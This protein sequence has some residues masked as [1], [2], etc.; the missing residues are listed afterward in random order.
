VGDLTVDEDDPPVRTRFVGYEVQGILGQ[1]GS[2]VVYLAH[3]EHHGRLV[4]IK[5]LAA[6]QWASPKQRLRFQ[7]E[8][9]TL[10]ELDIPGVVPIIDGGTTPNGTPWY[11]MEYV[12]GPSVAEL[13]QR[14]GTIPP[15]ELARVLRELARVVQAVH[16][17]G[18]VH[19]DIKPSNVL[20]SADGQPFL[21]DFGLV[22]DERDPRRLT[23]STQMLGTPRYLAPEQLDGEIGDWRLVDIHGLGL[24]L[25][26]ALTG[27]VARGSDSDLGSSS[28][29]GS[30]TP[31]GLLWIARRATERQP[32]ERYPNAGA[33]A[34]DLEA[35]LQGRRVVPLSR[36]VGRH[37]PARLR[38]WRWQ[39]GIGIALGLLGLQVVT[40]WAEQRRQSNREARAQQIV[41]AAQQDWALLLAEGEAEGAASLFE[42]RAANPA[43][44]GTQALERAWLSYGRHAL[45]QRHHDEA[46]HAFGMALAV[47]RTQQTRTEAARGLA[48]TFRD[49]GDHW[50]LA[51]LLDMLP[52]IAPEAGPQLPRQDW[53][54]RAMLRGD[55]EAASATAS[56]DQAVLLYA[57]RH[58]AEISPVSMG[59]WDSDGDGIDEPRCCAEIDDDPACGPEGYPPGTGHE[60]AGEGDYLSFRDA[61]SIILTRVA[62]DGVSSPQLWQGAMWGL[63]EIDGQPYTIMNDPSLGLQT[64]VDGVQ[65]PAHPETRR[66]HSYTLDLAGGDLDG[67]GSRELAVTMSLPFAWGVRLYRR[68]A[69]GELELIAQR[70]WTKAGSVDIARSPG[71]PRLLVGSWPHLSSRLVY[72]PD[73]VSEGRLE[74]LRLED[75]ALWLESSVDLPSPPGT[76]G[77][78]VERVRTCDVDGDGT[79]EIVLS[80]VLDRV[81]RPRIMMLMGWCDDGSVGEPLII[82]ERW[83]RQCAELDGDAGQELLLETRDPD[84]A[85][86]Q[87]A[88]GLGDEDLP[89]ESTPPPEPPSSVTEVLRTLG[90]HREAAHSLGLEDDTP[91]S[92]EALLEQARMWQQAEQPERAVKL[93][94]QAM[95]RFPERAGD[96]AA[97]ALEHALTDLDPLPVLTRLYEHPGLHHALEPEQAAWLR[98]VATPAL[99]LRFDE[100][101]HP[102]W[103]QAWPRAVRHDLRSGILE[104]NAHAGMGTILRLPLVRVGGPPSMRIDTRWTR[105][106][107]AGFATIT[108]R[109]VGAGLEAEDWWEL[110]FTSNGA[111]GVINRFYRGNMAGWIELTDLPVDRSVALQETCLELPSGEVRCS[112]VS[113]HTTGTHGAPELK[114]TLPEALEWELVIA[115][116]DERRDLVGQQLRLLLREIEL[117]GFEVAPSAEPFPVS[118]WRRWADGQGPPPTRGSLAAT[119]TELAG[120]LRLEPRLGDRIESELGEAVLRD[121]LGSIWWPN[122]SMSPME[123]EVAAAL[124]ALDASQA[125]GERWAMI[126]QGRG[127]ALLSVGRIDEAE[128]DL[129]RALGL[130]EQL[131]EDA[132]MTAFRAQATLADLYLARGDE[133]GC[134]AHLLA[135]VERPIDHELGLRMLRR[136]PQIAGY[137]PTPVRGRLLDRIERSLA[138]SAY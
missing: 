88:L 34:S 29:S 55:L 94:L 132:W 121:L 128:E 120:L 129:Q 48:D 118:P 21:T 70:R 65:R 133:E 54:T 115:T 105:C 126:L 95:D 42:E 66:L 62:P 84:I 137:E 18:F 45:E 99:V 43:L 5:V 110:E 131:G 20:L 12:E 59:A 11:A 17:Q 40:S 8:V 10:A 90:L 32:A 51:D 2:G 116:N 103:Q 15:R 30:E 102:A 104:V 86:R 92:A 72:E 64:M 7:R 91:D 31:I 113:P 71:G 85:C 4:A 81:E 127:M 73:E 89:I 39:L 56:P 23:R 117:G 67:D 79:D 82:D 123:P 14:P 76:E 130:C 22:L 58:S 9:A 1:G 61:S 68:L 33:M 16:A 49:S 109:P 135:A 57:L 124:I 96:A 80:L 3:S 134:Y 50:R 38:S 25:L 35:W 24:I 119:A 60:D 97:A 44:A 26:E 114:E 106:E 111:G 125:E 19:R 100:P 122:A 98:A 52:W 108:L 107:W 83:I 37:L 13:V 28:R 77:V 63:E 47:G 46:A 53:T 136:W 75:G 93:A 87:Y 36:I 6:G 101:L 27:R 41:D 112:R 69:D 74:V 78:K 138:N